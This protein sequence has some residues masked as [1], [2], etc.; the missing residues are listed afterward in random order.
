MTPEDEYF[1]ERL[2]VHS[3]HRQ[4]F[5]RD[6]W[7]EKKGLCESPIEQ[8]LLAAMLNCPYLLDGYSWATIGSKEQL[9]GFDGRETLIVPQLELGRF[10]VDF[11]VAWFRPIAGLITVAVEC[12]GHAFHERTKEQAAR[13]KS[14]D[15]TLLGMGW[16]VMRFTGSEIFADADDCANDIADTIFETW[17]RRVRPDMRGPA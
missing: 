1:E 9:N 7:N 17:V 14:R 6:D 8:R 3:E 16:P 4:Y 15:R 11:G 13:D 10:R 12:D 2:R 5:V